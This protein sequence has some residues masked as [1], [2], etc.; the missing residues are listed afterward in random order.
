MFGPQVGY[1]MPSFLVEKDVH[2]PGID[3][4]GVGFA[5]V[6]AYVLLGRGRDYAWSATSSGAD[7]T[8]TFV[9]RLCEP[10][11]RRRDRLLDGL[12]ARR[13]V[14][15]SINTFDHTIRPATI[16]GGPPG[17]AVTWTVQRAPDYGPV[18]RRGTFTTARP[19]RSREQALDVRGRDLVGRRVPAAE[20]PRR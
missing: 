2:G 18:V 19:S 4:R 12:R 14:Q 13:Q 1:Q 9:L 6:D 3:A 8:D 17:A 15:G 11:R 5:G 10:V 16:G 7:N 20:R